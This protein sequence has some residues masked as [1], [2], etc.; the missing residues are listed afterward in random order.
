[1]VALNEVIFARLSTC[2]LLIRRFYVI[3][4]PSFAV[5]TFQMFS[6]LQCQLSSWT[7]LKI[8][9][10]IRTTPYQPRDQACFNAWFN[11]CISSCVFQ[12]MIKTL[13]YGLN[14]APAW[15]QGRLW[16]SLLE[17]W[18]SLLSAHVVVFTIRTQFCSL[19]R[20]YDLKVK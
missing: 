6:T 20:D 8:H 7:I 5:P 13:R 9:E 11:L 10:E 18:L 1:M 17:T 12:H 15:F 14:F 16:L 19:R 3:Q 4:S 2:G